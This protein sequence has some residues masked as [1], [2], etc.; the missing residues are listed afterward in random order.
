MDFILLK[1]IA[2]KSL[3]RLLGCMQLARFETRSEK[4]WGRKSCS[5]QTRYAAYAQ[6]CSK[7]LKWCSK[8]VPTWPFWPFV[9]KC[10]QFWFTIISVCFLT[11]TEFS[12]LNAKL[13]HI[14]V[15][16]QAALTA[17][18]LRSGTLSTAFSNNSHIRRRTESCDKLAL[19]KQKAP[20]FIHH[21]LAEEAVSR[22]A[23]V[24]VCR[25]DRYV[26]RFGKGLWGPRGWTC[27]WC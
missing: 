23:K 1:S 13:T 25:D 12:R 3:E 4:H 20:R 22:V 11:R 27:G 10:L 24:N 9:Q 26:G 17:T 5:Q 7:S 6:A 8:Q 15:Q 14:M 16:H 19:R 2:K 18:L 21:L